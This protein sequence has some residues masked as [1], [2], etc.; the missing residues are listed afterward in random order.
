MENGWIKLH[1]KI[2][3]NPI[4]KKPQYF[5]LWSVLLLLA[6]HTEQKIIW[7][8]DTLAIKEGQLLTGRDALKKITGIP[9]STIEDI[10][11]YLEKSQHQIRQ[12]KTTKFRLITIINWKQYQIS[13]TKSNNRATTEQQQSDT[14]KNEE[15][16]KNEEKKTGSPL[17]KKPYFEGMQMRKSNGRWWVIPKDGGKWCEFGGCENQIEWK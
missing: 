16:D 13:D 5:T 4:I 12:Q 2:L 7:N 17:K 15:N 1:R 3:D 11:N 8:N 10:L 6:Q 9:T 14:Y